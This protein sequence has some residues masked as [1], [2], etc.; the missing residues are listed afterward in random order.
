MLHK[1]DALKYKTFLFLTSSEELV[2]QVKEL[3]NK[4]RLGIQVAVYCGAN[5]FKLK[6]VPDFI[7]CDE[8]DSVV[9]DTAVSFDT[10]KAGNVTL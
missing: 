5:F 3:V 2:Y 7:I 10:D 1:E 9:E 8:A 4:H 6:D